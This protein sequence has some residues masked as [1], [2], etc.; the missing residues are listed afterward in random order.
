M[1]PSEFPPVPTDHGDH[2]SGDAAIPSSA[3][4]PVQPRPSSIKL[5]LMAL[6]AFAAVQ[7][8]MAAGAF[9]GALLQSVFVH[10]AQVSQGISDVQA[11]QMLTDTSPVI[12]LAGQLLALAVM[13]PWWRRR[14][15]NGR[16]L[17]RARPVDG[18]VRLRRVVGIVCVGLALQMLVSMALNAVLPLFP[19]LS[20]EYTEAMEALVPNGFT[21][22]SL[23]TVSLLAP[24]VEETACRGLIFD[25]LLQ[26]CAAS[27]QGTAPVDAR[28]FWIA[29]TLQALG[30][31]C[32]HGN[33]VQ[34]VYAF[35]I[36]LVFGWI[37]W[38]CGGIG[39]SILA[40][41]VVNVSS[42]AMDAL[43]PMLLGPVAIPL[44]CLAA[45]LLVF[46]VS[47]VRATCD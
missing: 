12:I 47:N 39:W 24:L 13:L 17:L 6:W 28:I 34:G 19:S 31:A 44:T 20:Q 32:L 14:R 11:E 8:L 40:H 36:G 18:S 7:I 35:L 21:L 46:G 5:A 2:V 4:T 45:V 15:S 26:S 27:R 9:I 16:V 1:C 33:I 30:F 10:A 37:A 29:N 3:G 41:F 42:F 43:G 38:R 23:V 22:L 25:Y